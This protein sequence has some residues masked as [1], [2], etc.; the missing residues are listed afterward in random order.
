MLS[1]LSPVTGTAVGLEEV[2]DPVFAQGMVGP[3]TAIR[4]EP[5]LQT[6]VSPVDG[7]VVK[8]HPHAFVVV[9]AAD[10]NGNGGKGVL[11]HLGI[12]TVRLDGKGFTALV[13]EGDDVVAGQ[14]LIR[15]N[16]TDV[17]EGGLSPIVP[18]IALDAVGDVVSRPVTGEV[19]RG[20]LL[21]QWA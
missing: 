2:P 5:G 6:A 14:D 16:P 8:L 20:A 18:V 15:W 21:F 9:G 7:R 11:V 4:P 3:G 13:A 17:L 19:N 10:G 1:V 12:D